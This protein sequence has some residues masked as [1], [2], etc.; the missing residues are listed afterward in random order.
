MLALFSL[1]WKWFDALQWFRLYNLYSR[2][3]RILDLLHIIWSLYALYHGDGWFFKLDRSLRLRVL[4]KRQYL[5]NPNTSTDKSQQSKTLIWLFQFQRSTPVKSTSTK[6]LKSTW[7]IDV[8][9]SF[10]F[11]VENK[12]LMFSVCHLTRGR[13]GKEKHDLMTSLLVY[14][15]ISFA[16]N[17]VLFFNIVTMEFSSSYV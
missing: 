3:I 5:T 13:M 16:G 2:L 17:A 9:Y 12:L 6:L 15:Q 14:P 10:V 7:L 11:F 8:P 1:S 4:K